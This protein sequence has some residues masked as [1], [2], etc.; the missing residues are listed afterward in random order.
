ML[1]SLTNAPSAYRRERLVQAVEDVVRADHLREA[2]AF[3]IGP[4]RRLCV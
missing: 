1:T 4:Q 2:M 3:E